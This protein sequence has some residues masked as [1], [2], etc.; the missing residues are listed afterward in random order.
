MAD[1]EAVRKLFEAYKEEDEDEGESYFKE[2]SLLTLCK[3]KGLVVGP[4]KLSDKEIRDI[5]VE[6]KSKKSIF[7][8]FKRFQQALDKIGGRLNKSYADLVKDLVKGEDAADGM[9]DRG[10]CK[11]GSHGPIKIWLPQN[12]VFRERTATF[13]SAK[14]A[15]CLYITKTQNTLKAEQGIKVIGAVI[16]RKPDPKTFTQKQANSSSPTKQASLSA[17]I[18][19]HVFSISQK[20]PSGDA[21]MK[22]CLLQT[23]DHGALMGWVSALVK[24]GATIRDSKK[25]ESELR[26]P[27]LFTLVPIGSSGVGKSTMCNVLTGAMWID[28]AEGELVGY[29]DELFAMSGGLES[30][31]MGDDAKM[32]L[33]SW[34]GGSPVF[35]IMDTPGMMETD[36]IKADRRNIK[37]IVEKLKLHTQVHAFMLVLNAANVRF[38]PE[39][40]QAIEVL[41]KILSSP[42]AGSFLRN[43]IIVLNRAHKAAYEGVLAAEMVNKLKASL[44][45]A[46]ENVDDEDGELSL[47]A[48]YSAGMQAEYADESL[49]TGL[50]ERT[51]LMPQMGVAGFTKPKADR[52]LK[53]IL[54]LAKELPPFDCSD[55]P[56]PWVKKARTKAMDVAPLTQKILQKLSSEDSTF[57]TRA[58]DVDLEDGE[59]RSVL[60]GVFRGLTLQ[61]FEESLE[62]LDHPN[63]TILIKKALKK[64][65]QVKKY[66]H[67]SLCKKAALVFY[68]M[69][70]YYIRENSPYY[71]MNAALREKKREN[72]VPWRNYIWLLLHA[73]R[74]LPPSEVMF[75]TRGCRKLASELPYRQGESFVWSGFSSTATPDTMMTFLGKDGP[76]TLFQLQLRPGIARS[77]KDFSFF[78]DENELLL[79]F[80]VNFEVTAVRDLGHELTL[81]QCTQV[82][83]KTIQVEEDIQV[84]AGAAPSVSSPPP[85]HAHVSVNTEKWMKSSTSVN[86]SSNGIVERT[87]GQYGTG[88]FTACLATGSE[89]LESG[90]H[91]WEI[92]LVKFSPGGSGPYVSVVRPGSDV[93]KFHHNSDPNCYSYDLYYAA[94]VKQGDHIGLLLNLEAG[95]L[96]FFINGVLIENPT[97]Q[98]SWAEKNEA[99]NGYRGLKGPFVRAVEMILCGF[100]TKLVIPD[101]ATAIPE[102]VQEKIA[103]DA[104]EEVEAKAVIAAMPEDGLGSILHATVSS[105]F[106]KALASGGG[107]PLNRSKLCL[108]GEGRAGKTCVLRAMLGMPYERTASTVGVATAQVR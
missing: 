9:V 11:A 32:L 37:A 84:D 8:N 108:V 93:Q 43:T 42:E 69:E 67:M 26:G 27:P 51:V 66:A 17:A 105:T 92:E 74:D 82:E 41:D 52:A 30:K 88:A 2:N 89:V 60:S 16:D 6:V 10:P 22:K 107:E 94:G 48:E 58:A 63:Y 4:S 23:N 25:F 40:A 28:G 33:R 85:P 100:Q 47:E 49:W 104:L 103:L 96:D 1:D 78:P 86:I 35:K 57:L 54:A 71:R 36:G 44:Q 101:A 29:E 34:C 91:Y 65:K 72:V 55:D 106:H 14:G 61:G 87:G 18:E 79:P 81:V 45:R 38:T 5:F 39:E 68:T 98:P 95:T 73:L 99:G 62:G 77:L 80:N 19:Q 24:A 3:K 102:A 75:V 20:A 13:E 56:T 64:A 70:D 90:I 97:I 53:Q 12:M 46:K 83:S 21:S 31:A 59:P 15:P 50:L 7:I 76:R